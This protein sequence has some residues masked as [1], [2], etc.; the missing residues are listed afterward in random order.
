MELTKEQMVEKVREQ[1]DGLDLYAKVL[2]ELSKI[3]TEKNV[4]NKPR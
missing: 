4:P 1:A 2:R 3:T